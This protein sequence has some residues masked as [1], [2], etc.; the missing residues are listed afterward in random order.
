MTV[1]N[2]QYSYPRVAVIQIDVHPIGGIQPIRHTHPMLGPRMVP[3]HMYLMRSTHSNLLR[4]RQQNYTDPLP[5]RKRALDTITAR[6]SSNSWVRTQ[7][8][9][10]NSQ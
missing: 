8:V 2:K 6:W 9:S 3:N 7:L 5:L 1:T 4:S 10:H